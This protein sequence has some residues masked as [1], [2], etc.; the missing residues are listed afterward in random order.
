MAKYEPLRDY[1]NT[2]PASTEEVRL[3]FDE[4]A[5]MVGKLPKSAW[6][7]QAWWA[8]DTSVHVQAA[9][10]LE[11]GWKVHSFSQRE[12]WVIFGREET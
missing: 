1:L 3:T 7:H 6:Q 12:E 9:A 2:R 11:A 5:D 8:N 10:W 4:V